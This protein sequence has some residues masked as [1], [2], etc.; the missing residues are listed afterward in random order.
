[1]LQNIA[2]GGN[3]KVS[4]QNAMDYPGHHINAE[5]CNGLN[6]INYANST[7]IDI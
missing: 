3:Q 2:D 4:I 1:V 7:D 6:E 5:N